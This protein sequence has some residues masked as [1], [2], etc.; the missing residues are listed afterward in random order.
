MNRLVKLLLQ[1]EVCGRQIF[2]APIRAV[3]EGANL[4][5]CAKCAKLGSGYWEPKPQPQRRTKKGIKVKPIS[6][7]KRKQQ[8]TVAETLELVSDFGQ[9]VRQAREGLGL[10]HEDLGRKTREKVSV[11]RKIESGKMVPDLG[12]A[13]KLEHTL[14]I[15]LRVPAAEPKVQ[16]VSSSKP[17][18]TT[19]GDLI[20]FK[21]RDEEAEK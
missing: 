18:R 8:A 1:C 16:S 20:Q 7:S 9:R 15:T 21:L 2:G 5:V 13:E 17:R 12:L 4:S 19:L 14:K 10:S 11:L 6:Y 3:I